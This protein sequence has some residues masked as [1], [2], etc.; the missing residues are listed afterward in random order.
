MQYFVGNFTTS[1]LSDL[2]AGSQIALSLV[3]RIAKKQFGPCHPTRLGFQSVDLGRD[4]G[5]AL[6]SCLA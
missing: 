3:A 2:G 1:I 6:A 5:L 4:C